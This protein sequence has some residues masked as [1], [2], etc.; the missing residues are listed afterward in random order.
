[1]VSRI[2]RLLTL[3]N[4]LLGAER[5]IDSERIRA[6]VPGYST[7]TANFQRQFER[8]KRA[9][10]DMGLDLE[11]A[12][13]P[14]SYP[15]V[16]GYR[17]RPED[18][19]LRDPGLEPDELAALRLATSA[20]RFDGIEG[21]GGLWK[22]GGGPAPTDGDGI[23]DL[24][25]DDRLVTL[26]GALIERRRATFRHSGVARTVD[27]WRLTC[28]RGRWYVSGFDHAREASRTFRLDRIDGAIET[29]PPDAFPRPTGSVEGLRLEPW[30]FGTG[31]AETARLLVDADHVEAVRLAAPSAG[32]VETRPDGSV[33][34]EVAVTDPDAFRSFVLTYLDHAEVLSPPER[35]AELVAWLDGVL[36]R[37]RR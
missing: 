23:I 4:V 1:M 20:V 32:L 37:S 33:V 6:R 22:L 31:P 11:V 27:P 13:V 24:P 25:A 29:G 10:R 35:R 21:S 2:E 30:H 36:G 28:T 5:P 16:M 14:G 8:D 26:F 12:E 34:L 17:M 3:L 18:A 9:L 7:D 19:H 15:P